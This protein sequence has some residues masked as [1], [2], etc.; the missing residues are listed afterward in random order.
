LAL[1]Y[2]KRSMA[3]SPF[4]SQPI[5]TTVKCRAIQWGVD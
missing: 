3:S 2:A 4:L 5:R 1:T